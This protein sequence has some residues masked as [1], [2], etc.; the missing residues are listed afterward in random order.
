LYLRLYRV[1]LLQLEF[2]ICQLH[3]LL[4][5]LI[6]RIDLAVLL[7]LHLIRQVLLLPLQLL[8]IEI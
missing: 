2:E 7:G 3:A 6:L 8:V 5:L 1:K 4:V